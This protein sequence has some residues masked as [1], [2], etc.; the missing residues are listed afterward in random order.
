MNGWRRRDG[1]LAAGATLAFGCAGSTDVV[2]DAIE[3]AV[4]N[5]MDVINMSLGAS[6][7]TED[8][9]DAV[10][11]TNAEEAGTIVVA[12][13]GNSGNVPY[14]VGSPSTGAKTISV[15]AIATTTVTFTCTGFQ[16]VPSVAC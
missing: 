6:Y 3:W 10:A 7:G 11:S 8:S 5:H 14:I 4:A 15:A 16:V 12:S 9:S 2:T 13:A 1:A